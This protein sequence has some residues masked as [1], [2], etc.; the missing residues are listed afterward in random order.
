[1]TAQPLSYQNII[2]DFV[3][4]EYR[5]I[6]DCFGLRPLS[7]TSIITSSVYLPV[8]PEGYEPTGVMTVLD[9]EDLEYREQFYKLCIASEL[10]S[11]TTED[12]N[13][14]DIYSG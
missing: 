9:S 3:S 13:S 1:M 2:E 6:G 12:S 4:S 8:C 10:F 5:D 7:S 11:Y 14:Y